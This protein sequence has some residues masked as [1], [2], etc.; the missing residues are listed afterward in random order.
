MCG[1]CTEGLTL[2]YLSSGVR[3]NHNRSIYLQEAD[4]AS[5]IATY[6]R[7]A[8]QYQQDI[9]LCRVLDHHIARGHDASIIDRLLAAGTDIVESL[10]SHGGH[11]LWPHLADEA[12][13]HDKDRWNTIIVD[14]VVWESTHTTLDHYHNWWIAGNGRTDSHYQSGDRNLSAEA[15]DWETFYNFFPAVS[16][17]LSLVSKYCDAGV[18]KTLA[19]DLPHSVPD[20]LA[21]DLWL[22]RRALLTCVDRHGPQFVVDNLSRL[23]Y[24]LIS[25]VLLLSDFG[26]LELKH[27]KEALLAEESHEVIIMME[28]IDFYQ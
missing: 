5:D 19:L 8:T 1:Y 2:E 7:C 3:R 15:T 14:P 24:E 20:S 17:S 13:Y 21:N 6:G 10:G 4:F 27:L 9:V 16:F 23:R 22:Q 25:Y 18:I 28:T 26:S 11:A 12:I